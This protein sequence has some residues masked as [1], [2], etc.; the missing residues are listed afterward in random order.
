MSVSVEF[1]V[2][3]LI[4]PT[5]ISAF[6]TDNNG[7]YSCVLLRQCGKLPRF[8]KIEGKLDTCSPSFKIKASITYYENSNTG[9]IKANLPIEYAKRDPQTITREDAQHFVYELGPDT[10]RLLDFEYPMPLAS[11]KELPIFQELGI[12][13]SCDYFRMDLVIPLLIPFGDQVQRLDGPILSEVHRICHGKQIWKMWFSK[14]FGLKEMSYEKYIEFKSRYN[15]SAPPDMFMTAFRIYTYLKD[16]RKAGDEMFSQETL[17]QNY[18]RDRQYFADQDKLHYERAMEFMG[19]HAPIKILWGSYVFEKDIETNVSIV[20]ALKSLENRDDV[21][22]VRP[23]PYT[24]CKPSESLTDTQQEFVKH[25]YRNKLTFL[26][27]PPGTGKTEGLVAIM[28]AFKP[29]VVT[30][31]GMMVDALQKRFGDRKE[32]AN[33]IHYVCTVG[34][35]LKNGPA[36][37]AEFDVLVIDEG[38]NVD[39]KLLSRLLKV[40][41]NL[42]RIVIAGDLNQI[43]PYDPGAPFYDLVK[44][45]PQHCFYLRENKR[46]D[47]DSRALADASIAISQGEVPEFNG[48]CLKRYDFPRTIVEQKN[49]LKKIVLG[50]VRSP[51]DVMNFQI[52]CLRNADRKQT[53]KW[54]EEILENII[55][56]HGMYY[57]GK[58]IMF[59]KNKKKIGIRNGEL[60]QIQAGTNTQF[61]LTNGKVINIGNAPDIQVSAVEIQLGYATTCNK[62]QGSEWTRV[63]FW[64]YE[65][66]NDFFTREFPYVAVSR[67]KKECI[68]VGN[69]PDFARL[70]SKKARERQ[71]LLRRY[72]AEERL[73]QETIPYQDVVLQNPKE[74]ILLPKEDLAVP[75]MKEGEE[76]K[77]KKSKKK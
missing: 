27:G 32:T 66:P 38:S 44:M 22:K 21:V 48:T 36:W 31:V 39:T 61:S 62:A 70:I 46:V 72:L 57:P 33:T 74:L 13:H 43:F 64:M 16:R 7:K 6:R 37:L 75:V 63:L 14:Q 19:F 73:F 69:L 68:I 10:T 41:P 11:F 25:V 34:E 67:A 40:V 8:L 50:W 30:F 51:P 1:Y 35:F 77:K 18:C 45:L 71:T 28:S 23:A 60:G 17:L 20:D 9:Y 76:P 47:P 3:R 49:L 58:K 15:L 59:T 5:T 2:Q 54:V 24:P 12:N 55:H 26:L 29:L 65:D 53:S 56:K 52:V 42:T 4:H